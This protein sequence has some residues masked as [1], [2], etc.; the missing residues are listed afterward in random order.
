MEKKRILLIACAG[1][2]AFCSCHKDDDNNNNNNNN[3]S[4]MNQTDQNFMQ[5]ASYSNNDEVD[6]GTLA[7]AK[8]S[9]SAVM[10]FGQMMVTDHGTAENDLRSVASM[11]S[12]TIPTT[13]D[14]VHMA[15]KA[16]LQALSGS[17]FD[18]TFLHA[19]ST[20]HQ[21]TINLFQSEIAN[22]NNTSVKN[23]ANKYLPKIEMH[24]RVADS[25][26]TALHY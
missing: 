6:A 25:L 11:V 8:A 9:N 2:L 7:D 1:M 10:M 17:A 4:A 3:G 5:K 16:Q 12:V 20:D 22:G 24:K 26:I 19:Q 21:T 13:P 14:S 15:M 18:S 23:Y